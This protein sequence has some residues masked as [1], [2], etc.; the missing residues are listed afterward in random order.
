MSTSLL[1]NLGRKV[2]EEVLRCW[3]LVRCRCCLLYWSSLLEPFLNL[4]DWVEVL[5]PLG[6]LELLCNFGE[7]LDLIEH[8]ETPL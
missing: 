8:V 3:S 2:A 7:M 4:W 1:P 6:R 5:N